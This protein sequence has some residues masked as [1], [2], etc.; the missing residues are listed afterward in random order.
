MDTIVPAPVVP[1]EIIEATRGTLRFQGFCRS[2]KPELT[3]LGSA[4]GKYRVA[5][6]KT[7]MK[8]LSGA[9]FEGKATGEET[10]SGVKV[11]S[12]HRRVRP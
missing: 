5:A 1:S 8:V 12:V 9:G 3:F 11:Y 10:A 4:Y 7:G 6:S 2:H